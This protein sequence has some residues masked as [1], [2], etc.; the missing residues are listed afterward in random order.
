MAKQVQ[1]EGGVVEEC[2]VRAGVTQADDAVR[3]VEH[4]ANG[5]FIRVE[6]LRGEHGLQV[7]FNRQI[8]HHVEWVTALDACDVGD[9]LL[10]V[11]RVGRDRSL[12][13]LHF[14]PLAVEK[15]ERGRRCQFGS[16]AFAKRRT[17]KQATNASPCRPSA[18]LQLA[19]PST[20]YGDCI[21]KSIVNGQQDT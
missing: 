1:A 8:E 19:S 7:L 3:M 2:Q 10:F 9:G 17:A 20:G 6:Q 13:D 18:G 4:S 16:D 5:F 11:A 12:H 15:P 14:V 21:V